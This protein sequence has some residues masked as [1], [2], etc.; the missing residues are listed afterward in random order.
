MCQR[1]Q[2]PHSPDQSI[3]VNA[4]H[5]RNHFPFVRASAQP[6]RRS[7]FLPCLRDA[8]QSDMPCYTLLVDS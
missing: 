7:W 8:S 2:R 4:R 5:L 1:R 3:T 6:A